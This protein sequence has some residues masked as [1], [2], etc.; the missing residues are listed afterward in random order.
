MSEIIIDNEFLYL[1]PELDAQTYE[2]LE[3][4][5]LQN[6]CQHPIVL[7]NNII[8]DG[9]NRYSI[10]K[11]HDLE[12]ETVSKEFNSR[13]DVI[14]WIISTQI[15]RRNLTPLQLS[16]FRGLHFNSEKRIQGSS[17][18]Y[19]SKSEKRHNDVF[20]SSTANRLAKQYRVSPRTIDRDAQFAD[21]LIA[22]G[23]ASPDAKKSILSG[24]TPIT[25]KHL[26]E[27]AAD[28]EESLSEL[29]GK[30]EDGSFKTE[31]SNSK[32]PVESNTPTASTPGELQPLETIFGYIA[33][34]FFAQLHDIS[35]RYN[36]EDLK[37]A[38]RFHINELEKIYN[39]IE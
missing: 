6:G 4:D 23:E 39:T 37:K 3:E 28:S 25:R 27:L 34:A 10:C 38:L 5:I 17:N 1:L 21:A 30:I 12:F 35:L 20:H 2:M 16:Y 24:E 18:Q 8:I 19:S 26:R 22:I 31:H 13:Y 36:A 7:W 14:I 33:N 11:K 29:A 15:S 32:A 9:H